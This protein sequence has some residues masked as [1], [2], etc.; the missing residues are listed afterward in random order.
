MMLSVVEYSGS[1]HLFNYCKERK[2]AEITVTVKYHE[3]KHNQKKDTITT[4]E[5]KG[6]VREGS[7]KPSCVFP[8]YDSSSE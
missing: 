6:N 7:Y 8:S 1:S 5:G 2:V 4:K 3:E